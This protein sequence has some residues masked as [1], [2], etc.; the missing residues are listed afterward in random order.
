MVVVVY[1]FY[2]LKIEFLMSSAVFFL[3]N[4]HGTIEFENDLKNISFMLKNLIFTLMF[5]FPSQTT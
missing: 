3:L 2:L 4:Y 5:F 1:L